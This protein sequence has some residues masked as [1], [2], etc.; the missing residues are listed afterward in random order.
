MLDLTG[1]DVREA[2]MA[3]SSAEALYR[4]AADA[5]GREKEL[6]DWRRELKVEL[7]EAGYAAWD[8]LAASWYDSVESEGQ[9]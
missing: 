9:G 5:I 4:S 6:K 7:V 8:D 2:V 1:T 3:A